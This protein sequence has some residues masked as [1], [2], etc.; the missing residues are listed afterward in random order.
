MSKTKQT[1]QIPRLPTSPT[2]TACGPELGY[3]GTSHSGSP[4]QTGLPA[5]LPDTLPGTLPENLPGALLAIPTVNLP[6][7]LQVFH[8]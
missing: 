8:C 4:F 1:K 6:A 5:S 2:S 7:S 3:A